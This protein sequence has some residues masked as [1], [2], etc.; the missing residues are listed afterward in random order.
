MLAAL[1]IWKTGG[2]GNTFPLGDLPLNQ[3]MPA[4]FAACSLSEQSAALTL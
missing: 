3:N 1:L 2:K 4:I